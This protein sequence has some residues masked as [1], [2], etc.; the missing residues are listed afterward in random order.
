MKNKI[1]K[2]SFFIL[3]CSF[4]VFFIVNNWDSLR[5]GTGGININESNQ[6]VN[7]VNRKIEELRNY[8]SNDLKTD[9]FKSILFEI[10]EFARSNYFS[11]EI[12][13]NSNW[14]VLLTKNLIGVYVAKLIEKTNN[15]FNGSQWT[16]NDIMDIEDQRI[17]ISKFQYIDYLSSDGQSLNEIKVV[18]QDYKYAKSMIGE[19]ENYNF[20]DYELNVNYVIPFNLINRVQSELT[21]LPQL[22]LNNCYHIRND[23]NNCLEILYLKHVTYLD[24]KIGIHGIQF[25]LYNSDLGDY[26]ARFYSEMQRQIL[27]LKDNQVY[28]VDSGVKRTNNDN[29]MQRIRCFSD[30]FDDDKIPS[31]CGC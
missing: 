6:Y 21:V 15:I 4:I 18:I 19:C 30:C 14:S 25:E 9:Q 13:Q 27:Y 11:K 12:N 10:N 16:D 24:K 29:L 5:P 22:K 17:Y 1:I 8:P 31:D 23:L 7:E 28:N 26:N 20:S 2:I 3:T